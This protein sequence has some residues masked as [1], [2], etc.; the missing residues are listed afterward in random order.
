MLFGRLIRRWRWLMLRYAGADLP[1]VIRSDESFL[2]GDPRGFA[3]G[4][5]ARISAGAKIIVGKT[6]A[7]TGKL[8]IGNWFFINHHSMID[9]HVSISIGNN[10]MVGPY[11]YIADFDHDITVTDGAVIQGSTVGKPVQIGNH[12]WIGAHAV[13]LKGVTI[14]DGAVVAAG[15]LV[16][17]RVPPMAV[18]GG[19][20]AQILKF[21][22]QASRSGNIGN[23]P[24][25]KMSSTV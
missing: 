16:I 3:C 18:V 22:G 24:S 13:V 8:I 2:H 9:C 15:A 14:G 25:I 6:A 10:V 4:R 17:K 11:V 1:Y 5:E 7:G 12:V 19:V 21:R 23:E 20:P